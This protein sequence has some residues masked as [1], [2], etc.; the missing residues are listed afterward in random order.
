MQRESLPKRQ[1]V[2]WG[3]PKNFLR[4]VGFD[5]KG[6]TEAQRW[7]L[8]WLVMFPLSQSNYVPH[9]WSN[10]SDTLMFRVQ[11]QVW[12]CDIAIFRKEL[13]FC[14]AQPLQFSALKKE[15]FQTYIDFFHIVNE[16]NKHLS[17]TANVRIFFK[18]EK[19]VYI[20]VIQHGR[21]NFFPCFL[22]KNINRKAQW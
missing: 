19:E 2:T 13:V 10:V 14:F 17:S 7:R 21:Y 20:L 15:E 3:C 16:L 8:C 1:T 12:S 11:R 18:G 4:S 22:P 5:Q 9:P 6:Q